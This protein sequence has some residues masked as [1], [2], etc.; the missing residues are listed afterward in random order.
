MRDADFQKRV[1]VKPFAGGPQK[2]GTHDGYVVK[3]S[4]GD[5]KMAHF[6]ILLKGLFEIDNNFKKFQKIPKKTPPK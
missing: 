3:F 5:R 6:R 4:S 2:F 1:V